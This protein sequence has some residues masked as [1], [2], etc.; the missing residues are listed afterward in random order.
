MPSGAIL[1]VLTAVPALGAD[2][3][4][5]EDEAHDREQDPLDRVRQV[6]ARVLGRRLDASG[7]VAGAGSSDTITP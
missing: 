1:G 5:D 6:R 2:D 7:R 3:V 4:A